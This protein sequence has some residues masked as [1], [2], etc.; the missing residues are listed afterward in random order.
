MQRFGGGKMRKNKRKSN[1]VKPIDIRAA[2]EAPI[3]LKRDGKSNSM[4]AYE[5]ALRQHLKKA[6]ARLSVPSMKF[7][8]GEAEKHEFI[9][10]PPPALK[11]GVFVLPKSLPDEVINEILDYQTEHGEKD[12][13]SRIWNILRRFADKCKKQSKAKAKSKAKSGASAKTKGKSKD[14]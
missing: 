2:L 11:G 6:L 10:K 7:I 5:A 8:L 3:R 13:M 1:A 4:P 14:E 12:P 9:K